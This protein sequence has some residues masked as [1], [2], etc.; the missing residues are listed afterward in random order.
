MLIFKCGKA[1]VQF[2]FGLVCVG[3]FGL[4][5]NCEV[6]CGKESLKTIGDKRGFIRRTFVDSTGDEHRYV[7]FLPYNY[8]LGCRPP[9]LMFL[10]GA[11]ENGDDGIRQISKNFGLPIWESREFFPFLVV[12][13]QCRTDESWAARSLSTLWSMQILETVVR[14]FQADED[15]IYLTGVSAG[16]SAAWDFAS[17]YPDKFAAVI[18]L[19]GSGRADPSRLAASRIAIWNIYNDK[20]SPQIVES[21]RDFRKTLIAHGVSPISTEYPDTGH[22][23]W[24][25]GY[26]TAALYEWLLLQRRSENIKTALFTP[27]SA[28]HALSNWTPSG[29]GVWAADENGDLI[30]RGKA[31][32]GRGLLT[33]DVKSNSMELHGDMWLSDLECRV[34][35][36]GGEANQPPSWISIM[37]PEDGSGG[38]IDSTGKYV[39]PL[40]PAAQRTLRKGA[41]NDIRIQVVNDHL[42][43]HINGWNAID[44]PWK[45]PLD[46]D[47]RTQYRCALVTPNAD[48]E[49]RWRYLRIRSQ[50]Q[51]SNPAEGSP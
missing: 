10:N 14:E 51:P 37:S 25:R 50:A 40:R 5:V 6:S 29:S 17:T 30:G 47:R 2:L 43:V 8:Q 39:A 22:D 3:V 49:C 26:R 15:R 19:C 41:W 35:L 11:G 34:A 31:V 42:A 4:S 12:A 13:P 7:I 23:C 48:S 27:I 33:S 45:S 36:L 28:S 16:G 24:N 44:V 1:S 9:V 32:E 18:P 38:V 21:S 20:D 46:A